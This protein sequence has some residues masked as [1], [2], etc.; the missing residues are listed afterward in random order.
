MT[1]LVKRLTPSCG[2]RRGKALSKT[3]ELP[4]EVVQVIDLVAEIILE[5]RRK[6]MDHRSPVEAA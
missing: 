3:A 6:Q 4:A 1:R 2:R 5:Q